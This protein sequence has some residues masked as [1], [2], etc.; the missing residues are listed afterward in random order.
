MVIKIS[1]M[2]NYFEEAERRGAVLLD[3]SNYRPDFYP[4]MTFLTSTLRDIADGKFEL[5][6]DD[7]SGSYPLKDLIAEH[8]SNIEGTQFTRENVVVNSGGVTGTFD[9]VFRALNVLAK[10]SGR[11][12]V[13]I[14]TPAY[15]EIERTVLYDGLSPILVPT[16]FEQRF[17]PTADQIKKLVNRRTS[18]IFITSPGNP[19]CTYIPQEEFRGIME[20][21]AD[22]GAYLISDAIFE[23]AC[24]EP[25]RQKSFLSEYDGVIKIKGPSKDR[26]HMNDFRVGWSISRD[27]KVTKELYR[28]SEVASFCVSKMIDAIIRREMMFRVGMDEYMMGPTP[29]RLAELETKYPGISVYV[30]EVNEHNRKIHDGLEM[31]MRLCMDHP[32]VRRYC[33]PEA[34]NLVYVEVDP[35]SG[36]AHGVYDSHQL[37]YKVLDEALIGVTPGHVFGSPREELWFRTTLS[38]EPLEFNGQLKSVLDVFN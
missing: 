24:S 21:A 26:P 15:P 36:V 23:E 10:D 34:G 5:G 37:F 11:R 30:S 14:P 25:L 35:R 19:S 17:Q 31:S 12:E 13:I 29:A 9:G 4:L 7:P 3:A 22:A 2:S 27:P 16:Y 28:A 8:E 20:L 1:D 32:V 6:Y 38:R 18:A 33:V